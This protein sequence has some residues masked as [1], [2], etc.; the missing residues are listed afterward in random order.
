[1]LLLA[2]AG[3]AAWFAYT[4]IQDQLN[5]NKPVAVPFVEGMRE[6]LA[7]AKI[8]DASLTPSVQ[9]EFSDT[10]QKGFVISQSPTAG[11]KLNK[12]DTVNITVSKGKETVLV[13]SVVGKS[14]DDAVSTLAN[15]GLN[16]KVFLVPSSTKPENTVIAQDPRG[17][18]TV[19][20]GERVRINVSSGPA[21][22]SVPNVIGLQF[23]QASSQLQGAG[24]SVARTDVASEKPKGQ[25]L[26]EDPS[27]SAPPHST[28]NL[29]VSKGPTTSTV[30]DVTSQ[31]L[32]SAEQT[33]QNAGFK[34]HAVYQDTNDPQSDGVVLDE[35]PKGGQQA[36]PGSTVT[37]TVGRLVTGGTT[38]TTTTP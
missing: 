26:N 9:R 28:I 10:V 17:G 32:A 4:K 16:P 1:L 14:R 15:A 8:R 18:T 34:P 21:T 2:A 6:S 12:H 27:G 30:P 5:A 13:P 24:F 25:V 22:V 35:N 31:D 36:P 23:D 33:L 20:K 37:L 38:D 11:N 19:V 3:G 7:T 29:T